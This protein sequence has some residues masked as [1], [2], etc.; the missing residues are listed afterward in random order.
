VQGKDVPWRDWLAVSTNGFKN[1]VLLKG[2]FKLIYERPTKSSTL[3]N[4]KDDPFETRDLAGSAEHAA[5]LAELTALR[6]KYDSERELCPVAKKEMAK[7]P[8]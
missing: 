4:V 2:D 5:L 1:R 7:F 8:A 3:F 6:E